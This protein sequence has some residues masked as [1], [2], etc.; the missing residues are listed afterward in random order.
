MHHRINNPASVDAARIA[1][2]IDAGD[3]VVV[4]YS[5][6]CYEDHDLV[7]LN[8]LAKLYGR[9]LE[10]RFYGHSDSSFDATVLGFLR[11]AQRISLD[12]LR[13]ARN[14]EHLKYLEGLKVLNLG[15]YELS[16]EHVL[17][18]LNLPSLE[19]LTLGDTRKSNIDLAHLARCVKL[20][21]LH[22]TGHTKNIEVICRLPQLTEL[23]LSSIKRSC[24]IA[25]VSDL[26]KLLALRL[27]LGGRESVAQVTPSALRI[28]EIIRVRGLEDLGDLGRFSDLE[29]VSIQDQIKLESIKL[30][31]NPKLHEIRISNCKAL[32]RI[33]GLSGLG[34][35]SRLS[36]Y[37]TAI[38]YE[39]LVSTEL[40]SSLE[41]M[42]F[43]TG[44]SNRDSE[45]EA[46]LSARGFRRV[47]CC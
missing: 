14:L 9:D 21:R 12:C 30:G 2:L 4:Q 27:I 19:S 36:I 33:D 46:D 8:D 29:S 40:P 26:S 34:S 28:L 45:I 22:T 25:F 35:L 24:D 3:E 37:Q 10:I 18:S 7:S 41:T 1:A 13:S 6:P 23:S 47:G 17:G 43:Y 11:D 20:T 31:A 39:D 16:D 5:E 44:K 15:V 42:A 32:N 38:C